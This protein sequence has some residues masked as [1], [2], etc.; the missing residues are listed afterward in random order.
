[1]AAGD[2]AAAAGM[3]IYTG[4]EDANQLWVRDNEVLDQVAADRTALRPIAKG[5]TA[6]ST[7]SEALTKLGALPAS[8]VV[9]STSGVTVA[10]KVPR[11]DSIGRLVVG[12]PGAANHAAPKS[13]VDSMAGSTSWNGGTVTGQIYLPNSFAAT[14]GYTVCYINGDGRIS[15]NASALRFKKY[16][17]RVDP[18]QL[19]NIFPDLVRY[20]L[21][22]QTDSRSDEA[23]HYGHIADWL[24]EDPDTQP[25]TVYETE[26]D[27]YTLARDAFGL[28]IPLSID[29]IAL[30]LAQTAQLHARV[31]AQETLISTLLS[32]VEALE[33][34]TA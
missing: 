10:G 16:V 26:A 1:M 4:N 13:Y 11:Y 33:G 6:A 9:V 17:S 32:R 5:G 21:R 19:G 18:L 14:S 8:D 27:G 28:P 30:L 15:R 24:G 2:A 31:T 22:S 34:K 29:F 20:K 25:F 7:A 12:S 23:W 3:T